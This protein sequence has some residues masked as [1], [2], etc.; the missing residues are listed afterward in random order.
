[1]NKAKIVY[2][3]FEGSIGRSHR[4]DGRT[5]LDENFWKMG[6]VT[7]EILHRPIER[8]FRQSGGWDEPWRLTLFKALVIFFGLMAVLGI[9]VLV[10]SQQ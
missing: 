2:D 5:S 6:A 3:N 4:S 1:M 8:T 9:Y 7:A 10:L